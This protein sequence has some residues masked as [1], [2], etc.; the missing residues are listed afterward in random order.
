MNGQ[1]HINVTAP[2]AERMEPITQNSWHP[3][4]GLWTSTDDPN[5]A[6]FQFWTATFS[7][8]LQVGENNPRY[9]AA[10][11][12]QI[13]QKGEIKCWR[14]DPSPS[15]R[16]A[17]IDT[18]EDFLNF[19]ERY[20]WIKCAWEKRIAPYGIVGRWPGSY[21]SL[22]FTAMAEDFDALHATDLGV[23]RAESKEA[24]DCRLSAWEA[25]S[26]CWFRWCFEKVE[27]VGPLSKY[28]PHKH[29]GALIL[30]E[31]RTRSLESIGNNPS[32]LANLWGM[33]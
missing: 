21:N 7:N 2:T 5:T 22:N 8:M 10:R 27:D 32:V 12:N 14:L 28:F 6:A 4:G 3:N 15:A 9:F 11:D 26:T 16:I 18:L 1:L 20:G 19:G 25:E 24:G 30:L 31:R 17:T 23:R 33:D 13:V 29:G